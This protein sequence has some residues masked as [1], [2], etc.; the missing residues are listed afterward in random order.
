M[1]RQGWR[2]WAWTY[3]AAQ[4]L[5]GIAAAQEP[6][7]YSEEWWAW[8]AQDPPGA[9]QVEKHGKLWPPQPRPMGESQH[10]IHKFHHA[11]YWPHPY[12]SMDEAYTRAMIDIQTNN[13]WT[14]ATTLQD[15]HFTDTNQ[16]NSAGRGQLFWILTQAPPQYRTVYVSQGMSPQIAQVRLETAQIAAREFLPDGAVPIVLRAGSTFGRPAEEI[17]YLRRLEL[18]STPRPRLFTVGV[19]SRSGGGGSGSSSAL[20]GSG[21]GGSSSGSGGSS[22]GGSGGS[23]QLQPSLNIANPTFSDP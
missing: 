18:Q 3:V 9:R 21:S 15:Y 16:L 6:V 23:R 13:G 12:S 19:T 8:R 14:G 22:G 20:G 5:A 10:W 11:H 2:R 1:A 17:D 7:K 4:G